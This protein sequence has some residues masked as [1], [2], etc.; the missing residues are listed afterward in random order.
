MC[1]Q[2]TN[3]GNHRTI[4]NG[5]FLFL[6]FQISDE[7]ARLDALVLSRYYYWAYMEMVFFTSGL[8]SIIVLI[9]FHQLSPFKVYMYYLIKAQT[10]SY[11]LKTLWRDEKTTE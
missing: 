9:V 10:F 7:S 1:D 3:L 5:N 2:K 4:C 6:G 8:F 11:D